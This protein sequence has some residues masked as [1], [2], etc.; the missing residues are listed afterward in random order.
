MDIRMLLELKYPNG[1][2]IS[3]CLNNEELRSFF[4]EGYLPKISTDLT[5]DKNPYLKARETVT[6]RG[7]LYKAFNIYIRQN[8][9]IANY[10]ESEYVQLPL[11]LDRGFLAR[12]TIPVSSRVPNSI[13]L[14]YFIPLI[15]IPYRIVSDVRSDLEKSMILSSDTIIFDSL[16]VLTYPNITFDNLILRWMDRREELYEFFTNQ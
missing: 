9:H 7:E 2:S 12:F 14:A 15:S 11:K 1:I 13:E 3:D 10:P 5:S 6:G 4:P 16:D 8:G